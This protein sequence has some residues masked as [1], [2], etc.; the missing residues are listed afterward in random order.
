MKNRIFSSQVWIQ[1]LSKSH[2]PKL[3]FCLSDIQQ[4]RRD[5]HCCKQTGLDNI[6]KLSDR[7]QSNQCAL[8]R[9]EFSFP[10]QKRSE[11]FRNGQYSPQTGS[12]LL[13]SAIFL[14]LC[15]W[16]RGKRAQYLSIMLQQVYGGGLLL[17]GGYDAHNISI[18]ISRVL[19][20]ENV[21]ATVAGAVR[22]KRGMGKRKKKRGGFCW[23]CSVYTPE[24]SRKYWWRV[25]FIVGETGVFQVQ[26]FTQEYPIRFLLHLVPKKKIIDHWY[27]SCPT[28]LE[29][30]WF[31]A[32]LVHEYIGRDFY[33]QQQCLDSK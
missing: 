19:I 24:S 28:P 9:G 14:F 18:A 26:N 1:V 29:G 7:V 21:V 16:F 27:T 12:I 22:G 8:W 20:V 10:H 31:W 32:L 33:L 15:F 5:V 3:S 30:V 6:F 11:D 17:Y 4:R 2:W 23:I 25:I 13:N